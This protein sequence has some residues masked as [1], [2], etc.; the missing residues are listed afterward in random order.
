MADNPQNLFE[1]ILGKSLEGN[2]D[3]VRLRMEGEES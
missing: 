2:E 3:L 1:V